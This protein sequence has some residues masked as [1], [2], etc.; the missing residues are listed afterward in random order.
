MTNGPASDF[1][2]PPVNSYFV[3]CC[4]LYV[5]CCMLFLYL[6]QATKQASTKGISK[7]KQHAN[8]HSDCSNT[9]MV[10]QQVTYLSSDPSSCFC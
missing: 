10:S 3:V 1:I 2:G 7:V 4:M 9:L 6:N 5:V 8:S